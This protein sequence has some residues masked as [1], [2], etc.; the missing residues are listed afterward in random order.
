MAVC[1]SPNGGTVHAE[2]APPTRLL[3]GTTDGIS[4]LERR[5]PGAEW[6]KTGQL[7]KGSHISSV[8]QETMRGGLFAGVHGNGLYASMDGGQNW[9]LKVY[10]LKHPHVYTVNS[11]QRNGDLVLYAGTEPAHLYQSTDYGESW[12]ELPALSSVPG[13]EKWT[14]P[15]PP[16]EA[17][18]KQLTFDPR[19]DRVIFACVEQGGLFKS[20]DA[21]QSWHEVTGYS[22]PQDIFYN[23]CHRLVCRPANP[24]ELYM[25]SGDGLYNSRDGGRTWE[26]LTDS[27]WRIGYP[28]GLLISPF[29]DQELFMS[30]ASVSP[31][32]WRDLHHASSTIARSHDGGRHWE[33][34]E[35]GLPKDMK[36]NIEAMCMA[37]WSDGFAL[38]AGTTDGTV[39]YSEDSG[40]S[41]SRIASGLPAVSKVGHYRHLQ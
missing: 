29:D 28:D 7:L 40:E 1:L 17:H 6:K 3:I 2:K 18:V 11:V 9:E 25:T 36:A 31:V 19:D 26:H 22:G 10:G 4:I 16:H 41:W 35:S 30:G 13:T 38:F 14:F 24:D 5:S 37:T 27:T 34:L 32:Q 8:H 21:G 20:T 15:A 12:E 33:V 23:D 39:F